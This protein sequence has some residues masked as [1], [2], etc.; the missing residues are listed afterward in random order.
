MKTKGVICVCLSVYVC[1]CVFMWVAHSKIGFRE[2]YIYIERERDEGKRRG[3]E[4]KIWREKRVNSFGET[5]KGNHTKLQ[6][7]LELNKDSK[8]S[9]NL[10]T[11][12][13]DKKIFNFNLIKECNNEKSQLL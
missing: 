6:F 8:Q 1:V 5:L 9:K 12:Y 11:N 7:L 4:R 13:I 10:K 3:R 2:K